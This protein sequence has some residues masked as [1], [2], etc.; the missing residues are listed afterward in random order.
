MFADHGDVQVKMI[1][2]C[3]DDQMPVIRLRGGV[4]RYIGVDTR[5]VET[6][7]AATTTTTA[8]TA[9]VTAGNGIIIRSG[10]NGFS[11][12]EVEWQP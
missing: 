2:S 9:T 11:C 10:T 3:L 6:A 5:V 7:A 4:A 1:F 8:T 12:C